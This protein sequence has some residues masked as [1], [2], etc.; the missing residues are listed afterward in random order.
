MLRRINPRPKMSWP[1]R[2]VLSARSR[3]LPPPLRRLRLV[4]PRTLLRWHALAVVIG[5]GIA[6][7]QLSPTDTGLQLLQN[8]LTTVFGL[9]VLILLFGPVSGAHFNP[10]VSAVDWAI[11][12]RI[13]IGLT[14]TDLA[15]YTIVQILGGIGGA[16]LANTMFG[17]DAVQISH[18]V[19]ATPG[20]WIGEIVADLVSGGCRPLV[21]A[22]SSARTPRARRARPSDPR[23]NSRNDEP[24]RSPRT[25]ARR[26]RAGR[27]AMRVVSTAV[28]GRGVPDHRPPRPQGE[29]RPVVAGERG[30]RLWAVQSAPWPPQPS[31]LAGRV[32]TPRLGA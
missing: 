13:R 9:G 24:T 23:E 28:H 6:A 27:A 25:A 3:Q 17:L 26:G 1:D 10:A 11:G 4:S 2:A 8:S 5:S 30:A 22:A 12:S 19:R 29:G 31:R 20:L 15:A 21:A 14:A 18:H 16:L 7:Q 32:R